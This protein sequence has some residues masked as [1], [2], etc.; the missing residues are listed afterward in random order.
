MNNI[1]IQLFKNELDF[2]DAKYI[3]ILWKFTFIYTLITYVLLS[4]E[5]TSDITNTFNIKSSWIN[6]SFIIFHHDI[7]GSFL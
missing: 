6:F 3:S 5:M 1:D 7:F 4:T 2:R